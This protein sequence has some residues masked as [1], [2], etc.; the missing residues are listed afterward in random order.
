M[1]DAIRYPA[2]STRPKPA[3][4]TAHPKRTHFHIS[5]PSIKLHK[6]LHDFLRLFK[7]GLE[8]CDLFTVRH[9]VEVLTVQLELSLEDVLWS[10]LGS[11]LDRSVIESSQPFVT[12]DDFIAF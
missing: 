9:D 10:R 7:L 6:R 2:S 4:N 5:L 1:A 3:E 8:P 11:R 12:G